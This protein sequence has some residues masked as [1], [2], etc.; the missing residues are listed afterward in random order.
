LNDFIE[1]GIKEGETIYMK[2]YLKDLNDH[3]YF[4]YLKNFHVYPTINFSGRSE[5]ISFKMPSNYNS[6]SN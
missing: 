6:N 5:I 2:M 1:K 4:D 3:G